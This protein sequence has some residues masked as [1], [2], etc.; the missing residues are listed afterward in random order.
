MM[1]EKLYESNSYARGFDACVISCTA[2]LDSGYAITLDR[3]CFYPEGGGQ[4]C[5]LGVL[6]GVQV[7]AVRNKDG[8]ILHITDAPLTPGEIV[9]GEIDWARR[10]ALM[11]NHSGEHIVS[12]IVHSLYG[13]DNVGFHMGRDN[14]MTIDFNGELSAEAL[15]VVERRANAVVYANL[16]VETLIPPPDVLAAMT[17]R[18]KKALA[19]TVR[20]VSIE[21]V[22]A[23]AC[24]GTHVRRTGEIGPIKLLSA[25]RHKGGARVEMLCG[26]DAQADYARKHAD[27]LAISQLL[28]AKLME[29][30]NAV[31]MLL[32]TESRLNGELFALREKILSFLAAQAVVQNGIAY[33]FDDVGTPD[34]ARKLCIMLSARENVHAA[35]VFTG[36]DGVNWRYIVMAPDAPHIAARLNALFTGRGGGKAPMAQ[37]Q[38]SGERDAIVQAVF[39]KNMSS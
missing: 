22:D 4:P 2:W 32:E 12:G 39:A 3:S 7:L 28:S 34:D 1:V 25:E 35:Y 19:G 29:T 36:T 26:G 6:G 15:A 13:F 31:R 23:C 11:Q 10:F 33:V 21:G 5:D 38:L 8:E 20:I 9:H 27:V 18:S 17:Y 30:P 14:L 37:G 16:P 24:C